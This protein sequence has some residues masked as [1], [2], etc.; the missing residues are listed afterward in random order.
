MYI[1]LP[2]SD[3]IQSIFVNEREQLADRRLLHVIYVPFIHCSIFLYSIS[4]ILGY[5]IHIELILFWTFIVG[6]NGSLFFV[7]NDIIL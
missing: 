6:R 1:L 4:E 2:Y 7:L 5:T 3:S